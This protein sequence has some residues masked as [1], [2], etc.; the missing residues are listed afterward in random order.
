MAVEEKDAVALGQ[1]Q[2]IQA[3]SVDRPGI[4]VRRAIEVGSF[5]AYRLAANSILFSYNR[6]ILLHG[7]RRL[8]QIVP[9]CRRVAPA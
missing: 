9:M 1:I 5:V 8:P 3:V 7:G 2:M 4:C 6:K